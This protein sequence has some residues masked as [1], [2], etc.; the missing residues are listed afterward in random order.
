ML[1]TNDIEKKSAKSC[2]TGV[3]FSIIM[4]FHSF[5]MFFFRLNSSI[6][7]NNRNTNKH[8][9]LQVYIIIIILLVAC[10]QCCYIFVN[11]FTSCVTDRYLP[12]NTL[13]Y[14]RLSAH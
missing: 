7:L 14:I 2:K 5:A 13:L 8:E 12:S 3:I 1:K 10:A 6:Y 11:P 4:V 9:I